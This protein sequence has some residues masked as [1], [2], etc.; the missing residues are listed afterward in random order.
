MHGIYVT[1]KASSSTGAQGASE[2]RIRRIS[3]RY[4]DGT[5]TFVPEA[6]EEFFSQDDVH[7]LVG[8]LQQSSQALEWG[9]APDGIPDSE[10]GSGLV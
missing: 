1:R 10:Q 8:L 7:R 2:I 9:T 3:I 5:V 4:E 6:G